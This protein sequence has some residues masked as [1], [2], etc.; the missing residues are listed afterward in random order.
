MKKLFL[1][2][3]IIIILIIG[4]VYGT[5]FTKYGNGIIASY[6]ESKVNDG[7]EDVKLKVNDFRLTFNTINFDA[8][9]ND[10]SQILISGDL[11]IFKQSV[12]LKYDIKINDL[13]TLK[14]LTKQDLKGPFST[15]G[16][17]VG[18]KNNA[19]IQGF[20]NIALSETNYHLNLVNFEPKNINLNLKDAKIEELLTL[21]NKPNYANGT[22]NITADI[23]NIDVTNLDGMITASI[24]K[25][26]INND[27]VNKEFKQTI[28]SAINIET[29]INASLLGKKVEIKSEVISSIADI[30]LDKTVIDLE[31][32]KTFSDYRIDV[33]NLNKLEGV[34]GKKLNGDFYTSGNIF[35][36]NSNI[37]IAGNSN[38][39]ESTSTYNLKLKDSNLENINFK[40]EDAK[41]EKLL[42]MLNE[43]VYATG[44]LNID[45]D[46]KNAKIETLDGLINT[47][48]SEGEII[49]EVVNT[50]FNQKIKDTVT[51]DLNVDTSLVPNQA[52]SKADINTNLLN[53]NVNKAVFDFNEASFT[54]DYLVKIPSLT[55][56][57]DF[58][59]T[60]LRGA[61]DI[62]GNIQSKENL[63]LV[64]G[65]SNLL[66]GALNFNLNNDNLTATLNN[67]GIKELTYMLYQP[68]IF[69]SKGTFKVDYNMLVKKGNLTGSL[70]NGHFLPNDFSTLIN[71]LAKFDLTKEIYETVNINSD[72]N[73]TILTSTVNMKSTNTQIDINNSVF[74][75]QN[76]TIDA[77][78]EAK[79]K[80]TKFN[81]NINGNTSN[82][83]ISFDTKDLLKNEI[84]KQL[85]KNEGKIEEKINKALGGKLED[86]KAKEL[87]NNLKSFF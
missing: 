76:N 28:T 84:D 49:D 37:S 77:T 18:D 15:N 75:T 22:L 29:N 4:S 27:I 20:T 83:K 67:I 11:A 65:N 69:D 30:F 32:N 34:I 23:K 63:L 85:E 14:N 31:K 73:D 61:M 64:D 55:D 25:G 66:G 70:V 26:K 59:K 8:K 17:F 41:I 3:T 10:D 43:P 86:G 45:G 47:K 56:L 33:K 12:D 2:L 6:I 80:E 53:V 52:I 19:V 13:S 40:I 35:V 50:V 38:I 44:N 68:E 42:H 87:I 16:T 82:P 71:Q 36:E 62:S 79:I 58:T 48:I 7:Q 57:I 39:F 24:S 81:I 60:K 21:L 1:F 78:L 51:F 54:S 74:D 72:I 9:I 5:L 46:I